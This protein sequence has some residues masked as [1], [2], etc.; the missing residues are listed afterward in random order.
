MASILHLPIQQ[1]FTAKPSLAKRLLCVSKRR[2]NFCLLQKSRGL[3]NHI[4]R[5]TNV[6]TRFRPKSST[7]TNRSKCNITEKTD[8]KWLLNVNK[9]NS[10]FG[11]KWY[12]YF[13]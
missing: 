6:T 13:G 1:P 3:K 2:S 7:A 9:K 10:A 11:T 4:A 8:H 12:C 5:S